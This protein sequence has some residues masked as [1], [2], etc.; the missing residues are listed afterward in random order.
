MGKIG[1]KRFLVFIL[2]AAYLFVTLSHIHFIKRYNP[3]K[4]DITYS[5]SI[6]KKQSA[7]NA[8]G[9]LKVLLKRIDKNLT[10]KSKVISQQ[11]TLYYR[12]FLFLFSETI[13]Q[14]SVLPAVVVLNRSQS[15]PAVLCCF[16]L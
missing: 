9:S 16:R 14:V 5:V 6:F 13:Q 4:A 15:L 12:S 1:N 7:T 11:I 8:L 2:S 3:L 10:K